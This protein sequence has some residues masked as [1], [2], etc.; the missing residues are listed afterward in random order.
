MHGNGYQPVFDMH[1][2]GG[3]LQQGMIG[4]MTVVSIHLL[5]NVAGSLS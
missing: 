2:L 5:H 1:K 3:I 4:Y